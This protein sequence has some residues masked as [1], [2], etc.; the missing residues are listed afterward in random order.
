MY[1]IMLIQQFSNI[2]EYVKYVLQ[3]FV[4]VLN[5]NVIIKLYAFI[6]IGKFDLQFIKKIL[7]TS[8]YLHE[9]LNSVISL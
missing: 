6:F 3:I 4:H 8:H 2:E 9:M 7:M 5:V 1:I